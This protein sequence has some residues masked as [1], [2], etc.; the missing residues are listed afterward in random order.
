MPW[1]APALPSKAERCGCGWLRTAAL[2]LVC[3]AVGT[4]TSAAAEAAH[5]WAFIGV[6]DRSMPQVEAACRENGVTATFFKGQAFNETQPPELAAKHELVFVLNLEPEQVPALT[7]RLQ[8]A[9]TLNPAQRVLPL[10]ARGTQADLEKAGLLL[11]DEALPAYWR[12]NGSINVRRLVRYCLTKYAGGTAVIEPPVLIPDSGCYDPEQ[13]EAFASVEKLIAF[14]RGRQRWK[15]GAPVAALLLQQSFWITRDLRV[16]DAQISALEKQGL[17]VVPVFGDREEHVVKLAREAQPTILVE[18]R[19]GA[20][21]QSTALLKELGAPYLRPIS[22]LAT[23]NEEWLRDPRGLSARDVGMFMALQESWGTLEPVVVGGLKES[24]Q[25]FRLHEPI[26]D[27]VEAFAARAARWAAL[28]R[29]GNAEKKLAFIYYNKG[30]GQDDLMRGSPTGGFMDAPE[31]FMRFLP[32]LQKAGYQVEH[33]PASAAD[34]IAAMKKGGRNI[35]PWAQGDLEKLVDEGNPVLVPLHEY[36]RWFD[37]RLSEANRRAITEKFGPPPGRLM[38]VQ[39]NGEPQLVLP[40]LELGNV[41]LMPQPERGEKQ[42]ESLLHNR[43]TPPTHNYLAFYWWLEEHFHADAVVHWGTHGTLE[44]LPG[45]EAGLSKDCWSDVCVGRLPVINLWITDNLG[46]ATLSR[47]RSYAA[48]VDHLPPPSL[49]AGLDDQLKN[50]HDDIH[51]FR[52]LEEG[53]LKEEFRKRI[54][55]QAEQQRLHGAATTAGQPLD[56]AGVARLD[57]HLHNLLEARTPLSLHV[58][59]QPPSAEEMVPYLVQILGEPL[60]EHLSAARGSVRATAEHTHVD[61]R[62]AEQYLAAALAG[63]LPPG[64]PRT[65]ELEKDL[66]AAKDMRARLLDSGREISGLITALSGSYIEPGPGPEPI[67]N[68]ASAPGGRNLYSL[69][70]EEI[71]TRPAW[72]TARKL[73]DELIRQKHPQKIALDLNGMETMRDFGVMEGQILALLGVRPVWNA[74]NLVIDVE[75]IPAAELGRPRVEVF[76]AMGGQ[77]KENFPTRVTLLDKAVRLAAAAPE[78]ANPVRD[79][80]A[81]THARLLQKGYSAARAEQFAAARIFGTKP[82]N[83][84]GTNILYLV[85]RSG[86][87]DKEDEITSIYTDNMSYVYTGQTWGEKVD[88]LYE[89]ALQNTDT[90]LRVWASNMTSQ[91]SNHHAYEYLGGLSMAVKKIT[92][93]SPAAVISDVRDP[94]GARVR[95]FE[96]VLAANL[97]AELLNRAWLQGMKAHDYA[98]AGHITEMV[99]NTFGWSVTRRESVTQETWNEVYDV[100]VKDRYKLGLQEWFEKT[101]PHALQEISATLLEAARKDLWQAS[102]EQVKTLAELYAASVKKH[103]DSGGLVSGGNT[104]LAEY[105]SAKLQAPG[106]LEGAA[107][108]QAMRQSLQQSAA[109]PDA[110]VQKVSGPQLQG[111]PAEPAAAKAEPQ[112]PPQGPVLEPQQDWNRTAWLILGTVVLL[113]AAGF[114]KRSGTPA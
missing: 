76:I 45:K 97:Q 23:T 95:D 105:T 51:K 20:M 110:Q 54:S 87:W 78:A 61:R 68:P 44:L 48:L 96:E 81:A 24:I 70:P 2:L 65:A 57:A 37:T 7:T 14:K 43:D 88:G 42:D 6:W 28:R 104:R 79:A 101:S 38:V 89:E 98:G 12:P 25:G 73:V 109:K 86:V 30:L 49:S 102:P 53:L 85:P 113:V 94:T 64:V 99:K 103:G 33:L 31:S 5:A 100:L 18:D 90:V 32:A 50:L 72:E 4:A 71:P 80:V 34:L 1:W 21:W 69:N 60:L 39:R 106:D 11:R 52:S 56:D 63:P 16:I 112:T 75:L 59:G 108:A 92:G 107:L 35:G 93:K 15:D 114:F 22:M 82:G 3:L 111:P 47:R 40:R 46:E 8:Q 9:R 10:D 74:N 17:N 91:L 29:K 55:Q 58:L 13:E 26:P 62:A 77:Y 41:L 83:M 66:A 84:S 19:H 67:R 36:Q 27:R